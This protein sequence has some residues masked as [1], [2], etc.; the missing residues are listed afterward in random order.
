MDSD[1][2][3]VMDAGQAVEF[4]HPHELLL[5]ESGH[6]TGMVKETGAGMQKELREIAQE[7]YKNRIS[8]APVNDGDVTHTQ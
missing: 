3:L 1:K 7:A 8:T 2:V 6:L 4:G 5:N